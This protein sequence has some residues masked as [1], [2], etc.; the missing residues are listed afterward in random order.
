MNSPLAE[1]K[2]IALPAEPGWWP[3]AYGWWL[4]TIVLLSLIIW[5]VRVGLQHHKRN[6]AKRQALSELATLT[7]DTNNWPVVLNSLLKRMMQTYHPHTAPQALF[8]DAWLDL[9][10]QAMPR[11]K[12]A[13]F[14]TTMQRLQYAL[15]QPNA[16]AQLDFFEYQT[17]VKNWIKQANL[18]RLNTVQEGRHSA[19]DT[20]AKGGNNV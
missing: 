13:T 14:N 3:P 12:Q 8:G 2:D 6:L 4:L 5:L 19:P 20:N 17:A 10:T 11:P 7:A 15:Y 16:A 1:L 9:L 18:R